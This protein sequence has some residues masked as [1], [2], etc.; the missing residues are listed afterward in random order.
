MD[1]MSAEEIKIYTIDSPSTLVPLEGEMPNNYQEEVECFNGEKAVM[2]LP[3]SHK[4]NDFR[5]DLDPAKSFP[6]PSQ[7]YHMN[8]EE[9]AECWKVLDKMLK[10]V[11]QSLPM[12]TLQWQHPCFSYGMNE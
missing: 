7:P 4:H 9:C 2:T 5:I 1:A 11:G 6:K 3:D 10:L 12:Q 8:Q